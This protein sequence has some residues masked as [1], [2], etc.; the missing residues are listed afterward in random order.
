VHDLIGRLAPLPAADSRSRRDAF[1]LGG[2]GE[3]FARF[4]ETADVERDSPDE[5]AV[6]AR[7]EVEL[8]GLEPATSWVR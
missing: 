8:A 3:E 6:R 1:R 7:S 2:R 5:L 4:V